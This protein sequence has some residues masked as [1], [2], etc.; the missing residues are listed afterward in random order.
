MST[1]NLETIELLKGGHSA[2]SKQYC[3]M[4]AVAFVGGEKH[5]DRPACASKI[6]GSFGRGLND[7]LPDDKR[8]LLI[9]LIP[10]IVGTADEGHDQERGLMAADWIIRTYTPTWL[11][12]AGHEAEAVALE[13]L[14]R[15]G[16]WD[17]VEAA[18]PVVQAARKKARSAWD[19]AWDAARAAA[20]DAIK[21][22]VDALQ[23][24]AIE[25]YERMVTIGAA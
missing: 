5:S 17:D 1:I 13:A 15:Q 10:Q 11:R 20:W 21:P 9:P 12:L 3:L 7:I 4:E 14:P 2:A 25:L 19:A 24:S 6:L 22:T 23:D 18:V 8:Q 16:T